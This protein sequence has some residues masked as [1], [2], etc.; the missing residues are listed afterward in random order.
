MS[1]QHS[2]PWLVFLLLGLILSG[3]SSYSPEDESADYPNRPIEVVVPFAAG[4]GTDTFARIIKKAIDDQNLLPQ[5]L[6]IVNR[7]GAGAT[8]GSRAVKNAPPDGYT[9]LILHDAIFTA[10]YYGKVNFG[11]EAFEAV[12]GTGEGAPLLVAGPEVDFDNLEEL[13][14][15]AKEKPEEATFAVNLGAS[16]HFVA[17]AI[18][19]ALGVQFRMVQTGSGAKRFAHL[20]GGHAALSIF[21][22]AEFLQFRDAGLKAIVCCGEERHPALPE[23]PTATELGY[24]VIGSNMYY[25]WVPKGT[26][27]ARVEVLAK[28]LKAA[29]ETD[30]VIQ[31]MEEIQS[32]TTY[33]SGDSLQQKLTK[34][35]QRTAA[36]QPRKIMDLSFFPWTLL[37]LTVAFA[38]LVYGQTWFEKKQP[39]EVQQLHET[40]PEAELPTNRIDLAIFSLLWVILYILV[41]QWE[42]IDFRLATIGFIVA[43][44]GTLLRKHRSAWLWLCLVAVLFGLG[45]HYI[46]TS[47][48]WIDLPS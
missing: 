18:E 45:L 36:I 22:P 24:D 40:H 17:L 11:P 15:F 35:D 25:W 37:S 4:G 21:T 1:I 2:Y 43:C 29:M 42:V 46:F 14:A 10:K 33:L 19:K 32:E 44:G 39:T 31:K 12:A 8:I 28:A 16:S 9:V 23:V 38:G 48:F 26:P 7:D 6:V 3:C 30:Y 41:L 34:I 20:T 27:P 47:L 13:I 5:P